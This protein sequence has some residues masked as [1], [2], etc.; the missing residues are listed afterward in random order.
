MKEKEKIIII[1]QVGSYLQMDEN[2]KF[3]QMMKDNIKFFSEK[4]RQ[5]GIIY[6]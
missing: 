2:K 4:K 1:K 3:L 5:E 6:G